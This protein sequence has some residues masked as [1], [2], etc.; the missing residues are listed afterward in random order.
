[1]L[2]IKPKIRR[3][4]TCNSHSTHACTHTHTSLPVWFVSFAFVLVRT[5]SLM[6]LWELKTWYNIVSFIL[7][8]LYIS[9]SPFCWFPTESYTELSHFLPSTTSPISNLL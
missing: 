2:R 8:L 7:I 3:K 1:M 6:D 9:S 4:R 5:L